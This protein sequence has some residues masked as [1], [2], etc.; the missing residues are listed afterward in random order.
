MN[1]KLMNVLMASGLVM[2]LSLPAFAVPGNE[3]AAAATATT[4]QAGG[5]ETEVA[6]EANDDLSGAAS[7]AK[8]D[9][10]GDA[11]DAEIENEG[12]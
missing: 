2:V 3:D 4:A 7:E 10:K 9:L 11:S 5:N 1:K 6:H 8:D 12:Q